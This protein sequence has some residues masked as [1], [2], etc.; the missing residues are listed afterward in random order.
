M[1]Y[2]MSKKYNY[3]LENLNDLKEEVESFLGIYDIGNKDRSKNIVEAR[4]MFYAIAFKR[5]YSYNYISKLLHKHH[6]SIMHGVKTHNNFIEFNKPYKI[7]FDSLVININKKNNNTKELNNIISLTCAMKKEE[8]ENILNFIKKTPKQIKKSITN[9]KGFD[10]LLE[11]NDSEI[12]EFKET[13]LKPFLMMLET[14]K[15]HKKID[16][17]AGAIISR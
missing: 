9:L 13:R 2:K 4:M 3:H 12:L 17:V 7:I 10:E 11:L 8:L 6:A 14:R 15:R 1:L 16:Y 5:N